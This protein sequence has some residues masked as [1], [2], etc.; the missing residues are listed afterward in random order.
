[1]SGAAACIFTLPSVKTTMPWAMDCGCT[2]M[3]MRS[4][5]TPN[6]RLASMTSRPLF[7][8]PAESTVFLIPMRHV[9][10]ASAASRLASSISAAVLRQNG[11]PDAVSTMKRTRRASSPAKHW[12]IAECSESTGSSFDPLRFA[13]ATSS[14]PAATMSSLFA[15]A[16]SMPRST[17][18]KTASKATNPSVAAK[19]TSGSLSTAT[20]NS[21]RAPSCALETIR[22]SKRAACSRSLSTC[23][24]AA[25]ATTSKRSPW[26][27]ITSSACVPMDPVDPSI[28]TRLALISELTNCEQPDDVEHTEERHAAEEIRIEAI[29]D[30]A[31][32]LDDRAAVFHARVA[33]E[34]RFD[35]IAGLRRDARRACERRA[36]PPR[37]RQK[38]RVRKRRAQHGDQQQRPDRSFDRLLRRNL[39][40]LR[41]AGYRSDR[42][43]RDVGHRDE[44]DHEHR[45]VRAVDRHLPNENEIRE[46][47][48]DI[49]NRK[50][51][52]SGARKVP[53][54][55]AVHPQ[56]KR[57]EH[58]EREQRAFPA[59]EPVEDREERI[60]EH[61]DERDLKFQRLPFDVAQARELVEHDR[62][63]HDEQRV[64]C[65]RPRDGCE[66]HRR[67]READGDA[68]RH[69]GAGPR[70]GAAGAYAPPKR[71]CR[72]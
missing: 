67:E 64:K 66:P 54:L 72:F 38:R 58:D 48:A 22:T 57:R 7:I 34:R 4:P 32:S 12:K 13:A 45:P 36:L 5:G 43:R 49:Q 25:S 26:R 42:H 46:E 41:T 63:E 68:A 18:A 69:A 44:H 11:P 55:L 53:L 40:E 15:T 21:P 62:A 1:M 10:C 65:R 31:V 50:Q 35:E 60:R 37:H 71:R 59:R 19:T 16:T 70:H 33:F 3:W 52:V 27:A 14:S 8:M 23:F 17:A 20:R 6:R 29:Q 9:G 2:R 24:P 51:R 47:F 56:P 30:A 61:A 28:A 39:R